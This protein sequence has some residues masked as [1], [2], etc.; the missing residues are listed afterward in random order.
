MCAGDE[1]L[2][3]FLSNYLIYIIQTSKEHTIKKCKNIYKKIT[4]LAPYRT[5]LNYLN[6]FKDC[7]PQNL[8]GSLLN[9][10]P[11]IRMDRF[12]VL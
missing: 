6:F 7:L 2:T 3:F 5:S 12:D 11:Q 9:T 1:V 10:L 4:T 8:L